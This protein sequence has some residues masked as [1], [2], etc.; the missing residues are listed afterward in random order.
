MRT[1]VRVSMLAEGVFG[2]GGKQLTVWNAS[3]RRADGVGALLPTPRTQLS[4]GQFVS[5]LAGCV[6][7]LGDQVSRRN[8]HRLSR[9]AILGIA[10]NLRFQVDDVNEHVGLPSEFVSTHR[11]VKRDAR[12]NRDMDT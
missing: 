7:R 4:Y 1:L 10:A 9:R 6:D 2:R 3:R 12:N 11:R 8:W 5:S